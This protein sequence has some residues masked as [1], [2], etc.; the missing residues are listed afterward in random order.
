MGKRS[1]IAIVVIFIV[2]SVLD[3][4]IH[5]I[6][7]KPTY[8]ATAELWRPMPEM[9]MGLMY[10]VTL[11]YSICF[12]LIYTTLVSEKSLL[13]GL[14]LGGLIGFAAG[15]STGFGTYSYMPIPFS[16]ALSWF[17]GILSQLLVAGTLAGAIIKPG[18]S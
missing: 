15:I 16:L 8:D 11:A 1:I 6:L 13:S 4:I 17:F 10:G 14:K 9:K 12:V 5:G 2:W 3:F 7:L 18:K